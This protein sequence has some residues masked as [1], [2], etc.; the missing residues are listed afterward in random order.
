MGTDVLPSRRSAEPSGSRVPP[1]A[2][3]CEVGYDG[4][5]NKQEREI[6]LGRG[7]G[8]GEKMKERRYKYRLRKASA[9]LTL[10][11]TVDLAR[12]LYINL[13]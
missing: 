11:Q 7:R 13:T 12:I 6:C 9:P 5:T 8:K 2:G 4:K 3:S 10:C 1:R